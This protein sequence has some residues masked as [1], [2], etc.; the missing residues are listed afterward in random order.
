LLS[1]G[2]KQTEMLILLHEQ[3]F[4]HASRVTFYVIPNCI[5]TIIMNEIPSVYLRQKKLSDM[6]KNIVVI[7]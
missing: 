7:D 4:P 6:A 3:L 2:V 1:L 5:T